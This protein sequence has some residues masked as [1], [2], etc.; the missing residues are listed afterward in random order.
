[1]FLPDFNFLKLNPPEDINFVLKYHWTFW[2]YHLFKSASYILKRVTHLSSIHK[3]ISDADKLAEFVAKDILCH[4]KGFA[5]QYR[6]ILENNSYQKINE[7]I[8]E[9]KNNIADNIREELSQMNHI[10]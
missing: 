7:I 5:N 3:I 2:R 9:Y 6:Y 8:Q 10:I 4:D 1:M